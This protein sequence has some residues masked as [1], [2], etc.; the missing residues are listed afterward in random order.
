V[1]FRQGDVAYDNRPDTECA[2]CLPVELA[3]AFDAGGQADSAIAQ[4]E[5]FITAPYYNRLV[6]IDPLNLA[7]AHERLGQLYEQRGDSAR[8]AAHDAQFIALWKNADAELQP[9]V[10][11]VQ[12]RLTRLGARAAAPRR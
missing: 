2:P 7:L 5:Q 11:A 6:D 10:A 12:Q 8:A 1:E 4:Y 9:R 3:R